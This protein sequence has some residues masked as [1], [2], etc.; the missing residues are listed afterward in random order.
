MAETGSFRQ[1]IPDVQLSVEKDTDAVPKDG[2]YYVVYKGEIKGAFRSIKPAQQM[3]SEFVKEI[4]YTPSTM[5][6]RRKSASELA[7]DRYLEEKD[8]Y[9]ANSYKYRGGGGR[10]GRGGV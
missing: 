1:V 7:T 4:G 6:T 5:S 2:K 9:W 3:F 10:G 8:F